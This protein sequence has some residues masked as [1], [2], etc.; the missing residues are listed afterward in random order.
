MTRKLVGLT[1]ISTSVS[2]SLILV[3]SI[4]VSGF[5][6]PLPKKHFEIS[7][8]EGSIPAEI[9]KVET[10]PVETREEILNLLEEK[11]NP[12]YISGVNKVSSVSS[13]YGAAPEHALNL[14]ANS[15][16]ST[17]SSLVLASRLDSSELGYYQVD[18]DITP[19]EY[20]LIL[21]CIDHETRSGSMEHR[22]LIAQ[23][24]MNRVKSSRFP[25]TI[26]EVL[27]ADNQFDPMEKYEERKGNYTPKEST[28]QVVEMVLSGQSPDYAQGAIYFCN[29]YIVG[30]D[31][32]FDRTL[33]VV[34]EIE[35]HRFYK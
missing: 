20:E 3:F 15:S 26:A 2:L 30:E 10:D 5:S 25:N 24:I 11:T 6:V 1:G 35:G 16:Q 32:W 34:C 18:Y 17:L 13:L 19:E 29:P 8:E 33:T 9:V 23:V 31:N 27:W 22:T 21:Y 4:L 28:R 14:T 12:H 7:A